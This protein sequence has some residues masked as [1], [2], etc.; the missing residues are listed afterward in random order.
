[1]KT[2]YMNNT[3]WF[4]AALFVLCSCKKEKSSVPVDTDPNTAQEVAI[5]RF[6]SK[7][8]HLQVRTANNGLPGPN[9]PINFDE[10]P[11]IT[12]GLSPSGKSVQYYNFDVQ[13]TTPAPIWVFYKNGQQVNGQLN[14]VNV[15]PGDDMY[16]DFW[17]VYKVN[18]PD[19]YVANTISSQEELVASGYPV[20]KTNNLVNCPIVPKGSTATKRVGNV[21]A[22]LTRGWYKGQIVF[23]FNFAETSLVTNSSGM[24][25]AIPIFVT[26]EINPGQPGGGPESGFKV[27]SATSKQTHNV[28]AG[29]PA[30]AHYSPLW[31]VVVYDNASFDNVFDITTAGVAPVIVPNAGAVNCPVVAIDY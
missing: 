1:M 4:F 14:V 19:D 18:V 28:L 3:K 23:Y 11:F 5:D 24:V 27:E 13:P 9:E 2:T 16:N 12:T 21:D 29:V 6:S 8:G 15:V 25:P 26:F 7:A 20:E 22:S 10:E 30:D 17:Q 31:T